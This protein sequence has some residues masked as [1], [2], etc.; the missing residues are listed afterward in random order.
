MTEMRFEELEIR[1][2]LSRLG[3]SNGELGLCAYKLEHLPADAPSGFFP[4]PVFSYDDYPFLNFSVRES[5][6]DRSRKDVFAYGDLVIK[7]GKLSDYAKSPG[8]TDHDAPAEQFFRGLQIKGAFAANQL[9]LQKGLPV[10]RQIALFRCNT[11][12]EVRVAEMRGIS[13]DKV[14]ES[15]KNDSTGFEEFELMLAGIQGFAN[16]LREAQ[17][18]YVLRGTNDSEVLKHLIRFNK[19]GRYE[20][21]VTGDPEFE[22]SVPLQDIELTEQRIVHALHNEVIARRDLSNVISPEI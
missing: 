17:A 16:R 18:S 3:L 9:Q 2:E 12:R 4:F 19:D 15:L 6:Y 10:V 7:T 14:V 8:Y 20:I 11:N 22:Y 5:I 21:R 1:N 13:L